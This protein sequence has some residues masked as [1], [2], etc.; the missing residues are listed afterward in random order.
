MYQF[1][2]LIIKNAEDMRSYAKFIKFE[3]PNLATELTQLPDNVLKIGS[4]IMR[5]PY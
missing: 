3:K 4:L 1:K 2:T 5:K